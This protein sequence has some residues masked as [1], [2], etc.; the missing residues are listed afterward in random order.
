MN[1]IKKLINKFF[2]KESDKEREERLNSYFKII[3]YPLTDKYFPMYKGSYL[4]KVMRTGIGI[5]ESYFLVAECFN[6]EEE[7]RVCINLYKE[8]W[9]N[10]NEKVI[11][12]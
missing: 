3:Y 10:I 4:K 5:R 12:I 2:K 9:L 8:Q 11:K 6:T 1:W 7:A